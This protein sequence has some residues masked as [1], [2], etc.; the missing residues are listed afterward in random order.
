MKRWVA[1]IAAAALAVGGQQ[2]MA[3]ETKAEQQFP[4]VKTRTKGIIPPG[5]VLTS[6]TGGNTVDAETRE[7]KPRA[8]GRYHYDSPKLIQ[9]L[10][11]MNVNTYLFGIWESPTDWDDLRSEFAPLA[12]AAGID[13][14]LD[15]VPPSECQADRP[16][17]PYLEGYC[18]RPFKL[19]FIAWARNIATLSL[20]YPNIKA[21]QIDDFLIARNSDLFT[22]PYLAQI[23]AT[24]DAINPNLGFLTTMYH[25]DY[26]A[27]HLEKLAPYI[28]GVL[29][30]YLG[31][32]QSTTDPRFLAAQMD[33]LLA[34]L[35]PLH[36]DLILL[37]YTDRFLDAALPPSPEYVAESLKVAMP[38]AADG[39]IGGIVAYGAPVNYDR[40]PT[41][42]SNNLAQT[43]EGRLS[44][45]QGIYTTAP[46][47]GFAEAYQQVT[48][49]PAAGSYNLRFATYDQVSR[50]PA[51]SGKLYKEVLVDDQVVWRSDVAD[52]FGFT[53][54]PASVDLTAAMR[55]K[56]TAKLSLKLYAQAPANFPID[57]GFDSLVPTGFTIANFGFEDVNP[58][59]RVWQLKQQS[60]IIHGTIDKV[61]PHQ[62]KDVYDVI[63]A[64]FGGQPQPAVPTTPSA[65]IPP[66]LPRTGTTY[67]P[68]GVGAIRNS[69]MYGKGR[70]SLFVPERSA[71][72]AGACVWAEQRMAVDPNAPRYEISWWDYDAYAADLLGY[73]LKQV[74]I[75]TSKEK[76]LLSNLDAAE[77]PKV[78]MNGQGN[79]GAVDI[80]Q[81]VRGE[82]SVV[83]QF[84]LCEQQGVGDYM[85]DVGFDEIDAVGLTVTNGDFEQGA[86]GWTIVSPHAGMKAQVLTAS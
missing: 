60:P 82:T 13:V 73:H 22:G 19:D 43:G 76:K 14:W 81:F 75:V 59:T 77:A 6:K 37:L 27:D 3:K 52:E 84:A 53:W 8:D 57:V 56:T 74:T 39:R 10:K 40:R 30:P 31:G 44:F 32:A 49:D 72:S 78:W 38:Y 28:D 79:W 54:A 45:A 12:R 7:A 71:T 1:L 26:T 16:E 70:L 17:G 85:I 42:A 36:L 34:K 11:A 29:F 80:A 18:S 48:V 9:R 21:W 67:Q 65:P 69:A 25:W 61:T 5:G 15:L 58:A 51:K 68:G 35:N 20:Q 24:Q 62:A 64:A 86:T 2:A 46:A 47:G 33:E 50:T 55:G 41:I 23:K 83:L 4:D 63:A 66:D